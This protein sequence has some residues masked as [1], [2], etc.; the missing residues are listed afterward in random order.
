MQIENKDIFAV[1]IEG[2]H[3]HLQC[4]PSDYR[5]HKD[6]LILKGDQDQN[7]VYICNEC[8]EQIV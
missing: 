4:T 2:E 1:E 8:G 6:D 5:L 7:E 3:Y